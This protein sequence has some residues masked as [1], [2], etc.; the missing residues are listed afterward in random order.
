VQGSAP[1]PFGNTRDLPGTFAAYNGATLTDNVD[2]VGIPRVT[3]NVAVPFTNA[4]G[5]GAE[6]VL[7][8]KLYDVAPG[9]KKTLVNR[10]VAPVRIADPRE[11]VDVTLPGIVHR[12]AAGH[13]FQLVVA[14]SDMAYKGNNVPIGV[15][16]GTN[17]SRAGMLQLPVVPPTAQL[18]HTG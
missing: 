18:P 13:H 14:G 11:L 3:L 16:L 7:F 6:L 5:P 9:G 17:Q 4:A 12:F 10:L 1:A 2:V 8:V 15:G